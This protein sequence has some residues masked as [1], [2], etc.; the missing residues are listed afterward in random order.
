MSLITSPLY[1]TSLFLPIL[2]M[3]LKGTNLLVLVNDEKRAM[4]HLDVF[5]HV[6]AAS[7]ETEAAATSKGRDC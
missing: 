5:Q 2:F 4:I 3:H 6:V 1:C 7:R